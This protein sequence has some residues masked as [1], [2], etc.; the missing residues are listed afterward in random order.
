[1]AAAEKR[2]RTVAC[3]GFADAEENDPLY[4]EAYEVGKI[5]AE[6]KYVVANGGGQE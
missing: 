4:K 6:H 2:I 1:M 3:L 5:L